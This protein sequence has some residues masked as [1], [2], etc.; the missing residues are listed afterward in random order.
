MK[1]AARVRREKGEGRRA[2]REGGREKGE[3]R[4]LISEWH[5]RA[6]TPSGESVVT[7]S[8]DGRGTGRG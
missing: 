7:L 1:R 2:K 8:L 3:G 4:R 6:Q 5:L